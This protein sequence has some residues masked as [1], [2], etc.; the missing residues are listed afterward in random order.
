MLVWHKRTE[1][2]KM[3]TKHL[4]TVILSFMVITSLFVGNYTDAR[5]QTVSDNVVTFS[6]FGKKEILLDGP[7]DSTGIDF[8]FPADWSLTSGSKVHIDMKAFVGDNAQDNAATTVA[9]YI[10][11]YMNDTW[12]GT[13][14]LTQNGDYSVDVDIPDAAWRP[15][16]TKLPQTLRIELHDAIRCSLVWASAGN[17][18]WRSIN[19]AISPTSYLE[20]PHKNIVVPTDL[21]QFPYPLY[22]KSFRPDKAIVVVPDQP[23]ESELQAAF[24]VEA[25]L[26]RITD[27]NLIT[28]FATVGALT[29]ASLSGTHAVFIGHPSAFPQLGNATLPLKPKGDKFEGEQIQPGDGILELVPSPADPMR[30]WLIVS[31]TNEAGIV[32]AAQAVGSGAIRPYGPTNLAIITSVQPQPTP[33][34]N[35][36]VT[37]GGLGYGEDKYSGYGLAYFSYYFDIP[38]PQTVTNGAYFQLTYNNSAL[39][40]FEESGVSILLNDQFVG[41]VRFNDRTTDSSTAKF[42]IPAY[43]FRAGKNQLLLEA[44]LA[45]MTPCIPIDE[46]WISIKPESVLHVPSVPVSST[47]IS[48]YDLTS[49]PQMLFPSLNGLAFILTRGNPVSWE[50]AATMSYE[51]GKNTREIVAQPVVAYADAIPEGLLQNNSQIIIGQ[52][53]ALPILQ[54]L[55]QV[56]P[57]PFAAGT[58]IAAENKSEFAFHVPQTT[59]VGYLQVIPS[60]WNNQR[61]ILAI[62]GNGDQGLR[63]A[64]LALAMDTTRSQLAGNLAVTYDN[65]VIVDKVE[66]APVAAIATQTVLL[67]ATPP[68]ANGDQTGPFHISFV[69]IGIVILAIMLV[70]AIIALIV[71]WRKEKSIS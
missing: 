37:L 10:D 30:A 67:Q 3:K 34:F 69:A 56:L 41:S 40:N 12:L 21:R 31:G 55:T 38:I 62:L 1:R 11:L 60:P 61:V 66:S 50:V 26:A 5:A 22:Q 29:P 43:M 15:V 48:N 57:A 36:D 39:L 46:I 13:I 64:S 14:T 70:L 49:Y 19:V 23:T 18:T 32:K 35:V 16:E 7:V 17:G 28:S 52:P 24:I 47:V 4:V 51:I 45:G 68:S 65:Q 53:S 2:G 59:P 58:D 33:V 27:G 63:S 71:T 6:A 9:G 8:F 20:L 44:N 25:A 42:N 54:D